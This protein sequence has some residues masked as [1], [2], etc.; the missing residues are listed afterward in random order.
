MR[1]HG[2]QETYNQ[3]EEEYQDIAGQL[4]IQRIKASLTDK[5]TMPEVFEEIQDEIRYIQMI[6]GDYEERRDHFKN[7]YDNLVRD[8]ARQDAED[9]EYALS[10]DLRRNSDAAEATMKE[11]EEA[12]VNIELQKESL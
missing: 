4:E 5:E 6:I 8:A 7:E 2:A 12:L 9:A 10:E 3:M 1:I 11:M